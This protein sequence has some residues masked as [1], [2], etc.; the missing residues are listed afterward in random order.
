MQFRYPCLSYIGKKKC[1]DMGFVAYTVIMENRHRNYM[2]VLLGDKY[3]VGVHS[4]FSVQLPVYETSSIPTH[5]VCTTCAFYCLPCGHTFN[6]ALYLRDEIFPH[7]MLWPGNRLL[8]KKA[9]LWQKNSAGTLVKAPRKGRARQRILS[10][11]N[12]PCCC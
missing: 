6:S 5:E 2:Y 12:S 1:R 9:E 7:C 3:S 10:Q 8:K 11:L 4:L